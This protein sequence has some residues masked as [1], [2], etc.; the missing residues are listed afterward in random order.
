MCLYTVDGGISFLRNLLPEEVT[1]TDVLLPWAK[2]L[3]SHRVQCGRDINING[4]AFESFLE[5][6]F[7]YRIAAET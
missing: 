5:A 4:N 1:K 7:Y 6:Y 2:G 3:V